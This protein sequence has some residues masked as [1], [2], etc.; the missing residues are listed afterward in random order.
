MN[1]TVAS[2]RRAWG[3]VALVFLF[4]VINYADKSIIGLASIQII[5]DLG[6]THAQ[7]G[8][9]GSAFFLLFSI[10][11]ILIGLLSNRKSTKWI[12][13][14]MGLIWALA[15]LPMA[16]AVTFTVLLSSRVLL[17]AAEGPAFPIAMHAVHKWFD[18]SRR[19]LPTGIIVCGA[20]FGSGFAAPLI[21]W[22]IIHYSWHV[23]FGLLSGVG[24]AWCA[25]WAFAGA[26]GPKAEDSQ[27]DG[28]ARTVPY[29]SLI[30]CRTAIGVYLAG[31]ASY[32]LI[33]LNIVWLANYLVKGVHLSQ[34]SASFVLTLPSFL[35][36]AVV[37]ASAFVSQ[38]LTLAG[39]SSRLSR[40]LLGCACVALSGI[41]LICAVLSESLPVQIAL[42][43][44]AFSLSIVIFTMSTTLI[45]EITPVA[46]RGGLLGIT[47]SIHT[48]AGLI[49]PFA[50]GV[51]IDA[52]SDPAAGLRNGFI[53][54]GLFVMALAV[55]AFVCIDP[56]A[57]RRKFESLAPSHRLADVASTQAI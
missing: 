40:G 34:Q 46:Q 4:M 11:G 47:N 17:G 31:F 29:R 36:V 13:F 15:V 49:A 20:A 24:L 48:T 16:G 52:A 21:T 32:W 35:Q 56:D 8:A 57:D 25:F 55:I 27:A 14:W 51:I 22:V 23:A 43:G 7:F 38:R 39:V 54:A 5:H 28:T 9:L 12:L 19:A 3:M 33:A 41:A 6:L 18:N 53:A 26:E 10:S 1:T 45:S 42:L 44:I 50:M 2:E 37:P 30:L